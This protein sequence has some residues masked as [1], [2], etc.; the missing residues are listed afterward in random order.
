[1][2][3]QR[4]TSWP[5]RERYYRLRIL[6]TSPNFCRAHWR[7]ADATV[8][9][10]HEPPHCTSEV[11]IFPTPSP[12]SPSPSSPDANV[13]TCLTTSYRDALRPHPATQ[14]GTVK[15]PYPQ[16]E[17]RLR[18]DVTPSA[19]SPERACPRRGARSNGGPARWYPSWRPAN[20]FLLERYE[21]RRLTRFIRSSRV[22]WL[23]I[24][25]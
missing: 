7:P 6:I 19:Y 5:S 4:G 24:L 14:L 17:S 18:L 13:L 25:I 2:D 8:K 16:T 10:C 22:I 23:I 12:T 9:L 20:A 1:M 3:A 21:L 11:T 15:I